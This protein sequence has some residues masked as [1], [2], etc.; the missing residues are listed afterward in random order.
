[1]SALK[2]HRHFLF[3]KSFEF[4]YIKMKKIILLLSLSSLLTYPQYRNNNNI[5][6]TM[7]DIDSTV[8]C[9]SLL[10]VWHHPYA[11]EKMSELL[12]RGE[13]NFQFVYPDS[14]LKSSVEGKVY[15]LAVI[16]TSGIPI[17]FEVIK[18]I[19]FG[20]DEEALR[21]MRKSRFTP[22]EIRSKKSFTPSEV[23]YKKIQVIQAI[24]VEFILKEMKVQIL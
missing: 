22:A 3:V 9:D 18:G 10:H 24:K 21:V 15:I 23:S 20:C 1:M 13:L 16:D 4:K 14:A 17:C 6:L 12:N 2:E 19:G 8:N 7:N 5:F 11:V